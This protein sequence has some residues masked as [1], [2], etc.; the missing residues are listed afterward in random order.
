[1][2]SKEDILFYG[3]DAIKISTPRSES[4]MTIIPGQGGILASLVL[5]GQERLAQVQSEKELNSNPWGKSALLY[6]FP[7]RLKSG[8]FIHKDQRFTFPINDKETGNALHGF[9]MN[10]P[11]SVSNVSLK[12]NQASVILNYKYDGQLGYY[13]WPFELVITYTLT[14]DGIEMYMEVNNI[15]KQSIPFGFGWHPY[16]LI[17]DAGQCSSLKLPKGNLIQIDEFMI[18]TGGRD[19]FR[20]FEELSKIDNINLDNGFELVLNGKRSTVTLANCELED[21]N[22]WQESG[23]NEFRFLQ[24]FIPPDRNSIAVEPMTCNID[25]F[26]NKEGVWILEPNEKRSLKCGVNISN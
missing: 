22:I 26:N 4:S 25:A 11:M 18:P 5:N 19:E 3:Q 15:S 14:F 8:S 20:S 16:F 21:L 12:D 9:G 7:N 23:P 6:P 17:K 10:K 1:M 13:P 24:V 2:F